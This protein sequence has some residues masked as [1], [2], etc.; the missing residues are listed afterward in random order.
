MRRERVVII[1]CFLMVFICLGF[2]SSTRSLYLIPITEA[3][4]ISRS[5]F[6]L[7]ESCQY[8]TTAIVNLFFGTLISRFGSKKLIIAGFIS[9]MFA[10]FLY[11]STEVVWGF[12]LG[13]IFLGIGLSW[14]STTMVGCIINGWCQEKQGVIMGVVL[15]ASGAGTAFAT[16]IVSPLIY[17]ENNT[18]GYRDSYRLII[19]ILG[20]LG[21]LFMLLYKEEAPEQPKEISE[22]TKKYGK[23][24]DV[25][26]DII[27]KSYFYMIAICIFL[28]GGILQG[29]YGVFPAYMKDVG[30][31]AAYVVSVVSIHALIITAS[32]FLS[33][34]VYDKCGLRFVTSCCYISAIISMLIL[35][36]L[37]NTSGGMIFAMAY[38]VIFAFALPLQ[39]VILPFFAKDLFNPR[40]YNL[41]L[42]L[43]VSINTAG[44]AC[45]GPIMNWVFDMCGSY[46]P[47]FIVCGLIMVALLLCFQYV[48]RASKQK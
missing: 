13:S 20:I 1:L 38:A 27:R 40:A 23:D 17:Q 39:T 25:Y 35:V 44:Y 16:Q 48:I 34:V 8:I 18:F 10:M 37:E 42:G 41:T 30:I 21:V 32:K 11:S 36:Y 31:D 14:T 26:R 9:L 4:G 24:A 47:V 33:G 22:K 2:C 15:A 5:V 46:K 19:L 45:S 28:S 7:T 3:L 6:S 12:Y 29:V 43:F